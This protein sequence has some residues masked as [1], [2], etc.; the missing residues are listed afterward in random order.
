MSRRSKVRERA[1]ETNY[2]KTYRVRERTKA[3]QESSS[4]EPGRGSQAVPKGTPSSPSKGS[5]PPS[6]DRRKPVSTLEP[7]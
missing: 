3:K 5:I 7:Q 2:W 6:M 1:K 4:A